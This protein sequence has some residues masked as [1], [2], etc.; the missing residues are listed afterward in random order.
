MGQWRLEI[1][2]VP[3]FGIYVTFT[4]EEIAVALPFISIYIGLTKNASGV[5]LFGRK[6]Y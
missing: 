2:F 4:E 5:N 3:G 1:S 6:K